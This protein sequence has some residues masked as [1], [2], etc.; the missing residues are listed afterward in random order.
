M[1]EVDDTP[2]VVTREGGTASPVPEAPEAAVRITGRRGREARWIRQ[3]SP[4]DV[5]RV[6]K[7][8]RDQ[9]EMSNRQLAQ[10]LGIQRSAVK[11]LI[12]GQRAPSLLLVVRWLGVCGWDLMAVER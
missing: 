3:G 8:A 7:A 2:G 10:E 12:S 11:E 1:F 4:G 9:A 5:M 6:L